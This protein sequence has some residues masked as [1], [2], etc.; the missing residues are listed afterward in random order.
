[1]M[2]SIKNP[3]QR[4]RNPIPRSS[5]CP[6]IPTELAVPSD[7]AR[8]CLTVATSKSPIRTPGST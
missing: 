4:V 2:L 7:V 3:K 1:M 6:P 5:A 8:L